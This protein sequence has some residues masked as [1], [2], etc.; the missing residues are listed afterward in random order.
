MNF[1]IILAFITYFIVLLSIGFLA[2]K[3]SRTESD[4]VLGDRSVNFWLTALSAHA[5][6]MSAWLFMSLPA[7]VYMG[8]LVQSWIALGLI[9]GMFLNWQFISKRLRTYTEKSDSYTLSSFFESRFQDHSGVLRVLTALMTLLFL[10]CYLSAGLI[11]MGY[12]FQSLFGINFF[13]GITFASAVVIAYTLFGG[14]V[15]I[16]WVDFFQALF[17]LA[18]IL[19]VPLLA[20]ASIG[21]ISPIVESAS[22]NHLPLTLFPQDGSSAFFA[23]FFL[24][25]GW[26]LG[27][28]GQPHIITKFMGIKNPEELTKSKYLGMTWQILALG[29]SVA[30]GLI[31]I[32]FFPEGL[33]NNELVF[34]EI[35]RWLFHP[36]VYGIVLCALIAANL[37][38]MDS[39][40]LVCASVV[41][42][43]LYKP[44][45][46][47]AN[48]KPS[49]LSVSRLSVLLVT[50]LS[51]FIASSQNQSVMSAVFFAWSGLGCTFAPL[52]V[53]SLYSTKVTRYGAYAGIVVGG[54][55]P[56]VW[57]RINASLWDISIPALIPGFIL[58]CFAI[59][60]FSFISRKWQATPQRE[61]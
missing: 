58:G 23:A 26:G 9:F 3:R 31:G 30:I 17:L 38:T 55:I 53:M 37:S 19:F 42:E 21:G 36:Y 14:F 56:F 27:Y 50:T 12:L 10:T 1:W 59:Y 47:K 11:A 13:I 35:V 22:E 4:F 20:L 45:A 28:P 25:F 16:A 61:T 44:W 43:D 52:I 34:V 48:L 24:A 8:G 49:L 33:E 5:S 6:D 18:V 2:H 7:A 39:Q 51:L 54:S 41:T 60:L 46:H 29:A 15:T 40:I 57:P 32:A